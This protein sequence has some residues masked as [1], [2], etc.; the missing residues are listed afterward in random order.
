MTTPRNIASEMYN[1]WL[2]FMFE[3]DNNHSEWTLQMVGDRPHI[4]VKYWDGCET[5]V[6][7][8]E[9]AFESFLVYGGP[10]GID[11]SDF[12]IPSLFIDDVLRRIRNRLNFEM[13]MFDNACEKMSDSNYTLTVRMP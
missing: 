3:C 9:D 4:M 12:E 10:D 7:T 5:V 8:L 2:S 13:Q 6:T 1:C 11:V